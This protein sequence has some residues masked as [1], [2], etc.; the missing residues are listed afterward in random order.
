VHALTSWAKWP[1]G[2]RWGISVLAAVGALAVVGWV[3]FVPVADSLAS[4]DVGQVTGALRTLRLQTAR[5]AARGR[6]LT[7]GAGLFAAAAL[8]FTARNFA[9]SREGQ[10]TDRYTKAIEQLGSDKL[11]VRLGGIYALERVARDSPRDHSTVMKVLAAFIRE[12]SHDQWPSTPPDSDAVPQRKTRPDVEGGL[13][14]IGRRNSS[15]DRDLIDLTGADLAGAHLNGADLNGADLNGA[16]LNGARL[17]GANL[18]WARLNGANLTRAHLTA[19][20]LTRAHLNWADLTGAHLVEANLVEA[21]LV[22]AHLTGADLTEADLFGAHLNWARLTGANLTGARLIGADLTGADLIRARLN[23]AHLTGAHLDGADLTGA[24]LT[25]TI[26]P[27][28]PAPPLGW[29]RAPDLD[30]LKRV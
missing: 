16:D 8:L 2:I 25:R 7:F 23:G 22:D 9:L 4:H 13:T 15:A 29:E 1:P 11:D 30:R 28:D 3:L 6:L 19:A 12:H 24:D 17:N 21:N 26:W 5:D 10:V 20:D 14:V 27:K 18:G